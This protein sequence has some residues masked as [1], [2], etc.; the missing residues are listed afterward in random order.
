MFHSPSRHGAP[1]PSRAFTGETGHRQFADMLAEMDCNSGR[2]IDE[3]SKLG[4]ETTR[5]SSSAATMD[6]RKRA[7]PWTGTCVTAMETS[8][9][10]AKAPLNCW[11]SLC[12][13]ERAPTSK[14]PRCSLAEIQSCAW[15]VAVYASK[16][17]YPTPGSVLMIVGEV[18]SRSILARSSPMKTRRYWVSW[19]CAGPQTV[20]RI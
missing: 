6:R 10:L 2:I 13:V 1:D 17:R 19:T 9:G 7:G 18:G 20:R 4:I 3:V 15:R 14:L 5:S 8:P 11:G 16:T 12:D